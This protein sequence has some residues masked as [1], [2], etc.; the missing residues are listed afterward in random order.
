MFI[1]YP[2]TQKLYIQVL[3]IFQPLPQLSELLCGV[4]HEY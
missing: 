2:L 1:T 4:T 3:I